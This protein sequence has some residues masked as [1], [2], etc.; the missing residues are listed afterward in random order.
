[1]PSTTIRQKVDTTRSQVPQFTGN[2][3]AKILKGGHASYLST[4]GVD[5]LASAAAMHEPEAM[6]GPDGATATTLGVVAAAVASGQWVGAAV[7][8]ALVAAREAAS[9]VGAAAGTAA[10]DRGGDTASA[11]SAISGLTSFASKVLQK[12]VEIGEKQSM[13]DQ[14]EFS[15]PSLES[16]LKPISLPTSVSEVDTLNGRSK[17][18]TINRQK[19]ANEDKG[20]NQFWG[21]IFGGSIIGTLIGG[22]IGETQDGSDDFRKLKS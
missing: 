7:L 1:V 18:G 14:R 19:E 4:G 3:V 15:K 17:I 8:A 6:R 16:I 12:S 2:V 5:S 21:T 20:S 13:R 22:A 11:D 9:G 10:S